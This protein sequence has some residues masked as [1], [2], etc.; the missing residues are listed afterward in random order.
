MVVTGQ[1]R[2][3]GA[4]GPGPETIRHAGPNYQIEIIQQNTS[5][6]QYSTMW[7]CPCGPLCRNQRPRGHRPSHTSRTTQMKPPIPRG[8]TQ[9][10]VASASAATGT[11][12]S[13]ACDARQLRHMRSGP[14]GAGKGR[15][16]APFLGGEQ[17]IKNPRWVLCTRCETCPPPCSMLGLGTPEVSAKPTVDGEY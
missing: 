9:R 3:C 16:Q 4:Q 12:L 6:F 10:R 15:G 17:L 8:S 14:I 2:G 7:S 1:H 5:N 11:V 13:G